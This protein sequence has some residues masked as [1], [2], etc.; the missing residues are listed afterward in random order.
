[1]P[2]KEVEE[3]AG[4]NGITGRVKQKTPQGREKETWARDRD[5]PGNDTERGEVGGSEDGL[6]DGV[7]TGGSERRGLCCYHQPPEQIGPISTPTEETTH[8]YK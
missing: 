7:V 6:K 4:T 5:R 2:A 3:H 1:M 8:D